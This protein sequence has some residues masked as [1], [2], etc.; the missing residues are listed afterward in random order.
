MTSL[1]MPATALPRT[2]EEALKYKNHLTSSDSP[3]LDCQLLLAHALGQS[4]SWLFAHDDYQLGHCERQKFLNYCQHRA[5]GKPLAYIVGRQEFWSLDFQ[6]TE[7]TLIPRPETE[8]LVQTVLDRYKNESA[9]LID[10][11]TGSGAIAAAIATERPAFSIFATDKTDPTLMVAAGNCQRLTTN[12]VRLIQADWLETF[13]PGQFDIIVSNPPYI[14]PDDD[15]LLNLIYEPTAALVSDDTGLKDI[16]AIISGADRCLKAGGMILLE[17]GF[18]QQTAVIEMF[19]KHR[20]VKVE[21]LSDLAG[22][23]RA[24]LA[25]RR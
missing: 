22:Q 13:A 2:V 5:D 17:H 25:Y 18:D 6:V 20:F 9:T 16:S 4:R 11:G 8:L 3:D 21:P 10:L 7:A 24:V 12:P 14:D 23:P 19:K 1:D 15:H